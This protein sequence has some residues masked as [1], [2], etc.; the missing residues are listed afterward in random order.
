M[1]SQGPD[2][3]VFTVKNGN[4]NIL[5]ADIRKAFCWHF[6]ICKHTKF[7]L[8]FS[9]DIHIFVAISILQYIPQSI[10][11]MLYIRT[12]SNGIMVHIHQ[13]KRCSYDLRGIVN[14]LLLWSTMI[15]HFLKF[16]IQVLISGKYLSHTVYQFPG[17]HFF[18]KN[19][20]HQFQAMDIFFFPFFWNTDTD[21][22]QA[23]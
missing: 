1:H 2:S 13:T 17:I 11:P 4:F 12:G 6:L 8:T 10:L 14:D 15:D 7:W 18:Y 9:N 23:L 5:T 3:P 21:Q 16:L 20:I 19:D 22:I